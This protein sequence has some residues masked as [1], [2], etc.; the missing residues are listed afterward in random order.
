LVLKGHP[1]CATSPAK[2]LFQNRQKKE[3]QWGTGKP[4]FAW[5]MAFEAKEV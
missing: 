5:K 4:G 2:I 3:N 1:V